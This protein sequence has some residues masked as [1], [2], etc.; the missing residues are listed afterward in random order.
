MP[1]PQEAGFDGEGGTD[2]RGLMPSEVGAGGMVLVVRAGGL[3]V[4]VAGLT[5][6]AEG[7]C[8]AW[9]PLQ[10]R[11]PNVSAAVVRV[12]RIGP[13]RIARLRLQGTASLTKYP[14][15]TAMAAGERVNPSVP[16]RRRATI[17]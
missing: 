15:S 3:A 12:P 4:A 10:A 16:T 11:M 8:R 7:P 13:L 2:D 5:L 6:A 1:G 14:L 9:Q 17:L